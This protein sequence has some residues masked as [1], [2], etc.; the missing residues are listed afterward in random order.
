MAAEK[1]AVTL[2]SL[3]LKRGGEE[4]R[5][6]I[7]DIDTVVIDF[8]IVELPGE[9]PAICIHRSWIRSEFFWERFWGL[10]R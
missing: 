1:V 4:L 3:V 9:R 5:V 7:E 8:L 10:Y 2:N 6:P